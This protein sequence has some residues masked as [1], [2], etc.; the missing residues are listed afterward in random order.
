[1]MTQ[2]VQRQLIETMAELIASSAYVAWANTLWGHLN[3]LQAHYQYRMIRP[4]LGDLVLEIS[5]VKVP[6][7]D[8]IGRLLWITPDD[9]RWTIQTLDGREVRWENS[10][11]IVVPEVPWH[12]QGM[13]P[14]DWQVRGDWRPIFGASMRE[15]HP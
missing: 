12:H 2:A 7:M 6:A 4:N 13:L 3:P 11:F 14:D 10:R 8:R 1:M 15:A 9:E 5:T